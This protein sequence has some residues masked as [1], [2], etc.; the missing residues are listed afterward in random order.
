MKEISRQ[1]DSDPFGLKKL[2]FRI[3][4]PEPFEMFPL[5]EALTYIHGCDYPESVDDLLLVWETRQRF[6][7]IS[8]W[9]ILD[10]MCGPGRLGREF[11]AMGVKKVIFHDGDEMMINHAHNKA[12]LIKRSGQLVESVQSLVDQI[13]L[14]DNI[15]DLVICHNSI[16][17]LSSLEKLDVV[18]REFMRLIKPGGNVVIAD[19]QR[20]TDDHKFLMALEE[21]LNWTKPEIVPL[22]IPTFQAAFSKEE[23]AEI[24]GAMPGIKRWSVEDAR[25]PTLTPNMQWRVNQD[26]VKG[27]KLDFSP[28][29]LRVLI[30]KER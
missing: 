19:Y 12:S 25:L 14:P 15:F 5:E 30:Q 1:P 21:R 7:D 2:D 3:R 8:N 6:G 13:P 11:L 10:A 26:P 27:H 29:S 23:F 24:V 17:Q 28:I 20:S 18:L 16:H 4:V 22:L 9:T